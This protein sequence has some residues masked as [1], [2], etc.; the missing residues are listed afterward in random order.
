MCQFLNLSQNMFKLMIQGLPK[1]GILMHLYCDLL[2]VGFTS[3]KNLK[4]FDF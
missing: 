1:F 2:Y 4:S 3:G